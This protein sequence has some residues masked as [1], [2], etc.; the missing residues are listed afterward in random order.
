MILSLSYPTFIQHTTLF[1]GFITT[2]I[3]YANRNKFWELKL[4]YLYPFA[5][6]IQ[7]AVC[8]LLP[9]TNISDELY[10]NSPYI[11]MNLFLLVE[12]LLIY[13]FYS[14]IFKSGTVKKILLATTIVYS[15]TAFFYW[16]HGDNLLNEPANFHFTTQAFIIL[17]PG[18]LYIVRLIKRP[19]NYKLTIFPAFWVVSG[20]MF[21]FSC[22][23]PLFIIEDLT[24]DEPKNESLSNPELYSI[25]EIS[26][27]V[28]FFTIIKA[29][30]CPKVE[31]Y[32][33]ESRFD[34]FNR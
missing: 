11:S 25:N 13:H 30:L 6:F 29:Y 26:Y 16:L 12:F 22:T 2:M 14:R 23:L 5:S 24:T 9:L 3:G 34:T 15:I 8:I 7:I 4:L 27:C 19:L 33:I 1:L 32:H 28:L 10:S 31:T 17:F 18:L 21:Y 20:I